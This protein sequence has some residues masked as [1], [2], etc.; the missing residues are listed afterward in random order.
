MRFWDEIR[1]TYLVYFGIKFILK[2]HHIWLNFTEHFDIL[3][4]I[5]KKRY[6]LH[7]KKSLCQYLIYLLSRFL[8]DWCLK[9]KDAAEE[10]TV[11]MCFL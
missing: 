7:F 2:S 8:M 9:Q 1:G 5:E 10:R 3:Y 6:T 11:P 4:R